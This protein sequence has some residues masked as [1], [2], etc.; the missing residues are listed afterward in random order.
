MLPSVCLRPTWNHLTFPVRSAGKA[1][2]GSEGLEST[3]VPAGFRLVNAEEGTVAYT[4]PSR[5]RGKLEC[6]E[7]HLIG[8][9]HGQTVAN[10]AREQ[11]R[12]AVL[13]GQSEVALT[14]TGRRQAEEAARQLFHQLG[15]E[16]WLQRAAQDPS[17]LPVV[18]TSPLTRASLT[19]EALAGLLRERSGGAVE[20]PILP[21]DRLKEI[22]FGRYE[23]KTRDDLRADYPAFTHRMDSFQGPGNDFIHRFPGGESRLDV[24]DRVQS[25]LADVADRH[26][27]K[28]VLV[29]CHMETMVGMRTALGF[30]RQR[31]GSVRADAQEMKNATPLTLLPRKGDTVPC[32][33]CR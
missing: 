1:P 21:D 8:M 10:L 4:G 26:A 6:A 17:L 19:A 24:V 18:Y 33:S 7:V 3:A 9:R 15:G 20:L 32:I 25:F 27:G 12:P 13:S 31:E 11:G 22:H 16:A 5:V 2:T 23:M 30:S 28:T 29:V 14:D